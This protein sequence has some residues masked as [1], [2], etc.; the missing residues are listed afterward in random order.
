MTDPLDRMRDVI[1]EDIGNRGLR[2]DPERNLVSATAG[3][4][5]GACVSL[6]GAAAPG[7]AVVTGFY[8]PTADPPAGETDGPLGAV[9]LARALVPLGIR[10]A[11]ATD[12]FCTTAVDAGLAMCRL[13]GQV[14]VVTLPPPAEAKAMGPAAYCEQF[15]R[16]TAGL[17]LRHLL[18]IER[19]GPNRSDRCRTMRGIDI[20]D[21]M[22][23]AHWLFEAAPEGGV[24][25]IGIGDGGNEIGMGKI[26]LDV[27]R[28]NI[29]RGDLIACRVPADYLIVAGVSN[30]G[31][32][33]LAAGVYHLRGAAPPALLFDADVERRL[34]ATMVERGPL[35]DGVLGRPSVTVD[36]L[37]WE[38]YSALLGPLAG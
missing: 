26:A 29:P 13:S 11:I 35:V 19:V 2:H 28:H 16:A 3:D 6:A 15:R 17:G 31:A 1:Q 33:G 4:F 5:R 18:A 22:S 12:A 7:L 32:Y 37:T 25:T 23:P 21:R 34:L 8:I 27:I 30:W 20:T 38:Q 36:G 14:Q 24:T 10:V 9:F